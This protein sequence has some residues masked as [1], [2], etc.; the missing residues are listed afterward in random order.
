MEATPSG[1]PQP[2]QREIT[3]AAQTL[4]GRGA[5]VQR[6]R[7]SNQLCDKR[8]PTGGRNWRFGRGLY[9]LSRSGGIAGVA[10]RARRTL[11][12]RPGEKNRV[13]P[14]PPGGCR[15]AGAAHAC[16]A[17]SALICPDK[18]AAPQPVPNAL[19]PSN[20]VGR[21]RP[22]IAGKN[23]Q[24][25]AQPHQPEKNHTSLV[26]LLRAVT[27]WRLESV[28]A[29]FFDCAHVERARSRGPH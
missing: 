28:R 22:E 12:R 27:F 13:A 3:T 9:H 25:Q 15:R 16:G 24:R 11:G 5:I 8:N 1:R 6:G 10:F 14:R 17:V 29:C 7:K 4:F 20:S 21:G 26:V 18:L 2:S 19:Q 23:S